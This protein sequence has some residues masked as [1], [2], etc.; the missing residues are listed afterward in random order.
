[1]ESSEKI[2]R[3]S[4]LLLSIGASVVLRAEPIKADISAVKPGPVRV[5]TN[6][7]QLTARWSDAGG[8]EW[9]AGF[10]LDT[11][12]P[13][14]TSISVEGHSVIEQA[15]P[16]YRCS[17]GKR[18]GGWDAF[19]DFPPAAP[20][21]TRSDLQRFHPTEATSRTVGNRLE[22]SFNGME[23]GIFSGDLRYIIYPGSSL[24]QQI[25][26]LKTAEPDVAYTYDTGIQMAVEGDR[27][28]GVNM[29]SKIA[30]YDADTK[31]QSL[32]PPYGSERHT[33]QVHY[34][35]LAARTGTGSIVAFPSPHRYL[36]AR[37][38]ST[39]MGYAWYSSWRGRVG[40]GIQQPLDDNT[41]IYPWMNAPPGTAQEMGIFFL[42][43]SGA[44]ADTL[45]VTQ[46]A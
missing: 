10:A 35:A 29:A 44:P 25:A 17:T 41:Q 2:V 18:T 3:V 15:T 26:V 21:G 16:Y 9:T 40:I 23:L 34:R 1:M 33:L 14:I 37:D 19:F 42:L 8:R 43:G 36:F 30:Y 38:Y 31:L 12:L 39:N 6:N 20:G 11:R 27:S 46:A 4:A 22:V 28:P 32:T 24:I 45:Q 13:L 7:S 5:A